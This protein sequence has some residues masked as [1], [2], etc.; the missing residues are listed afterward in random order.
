[1]W[2]GFAAARLGGRVSDISH[3]VEAR[4]SAQPGRLR[5]PRGLHRPRHRHGDAPAAQRAQLRPTRPRARSSSEGSPWRS[6]RWSTLGSR[7]TDARRRRV[8]RRHRRRQLGRALRAHLHA[9][10]RTAPGSSPRSTAAR[11]SWPSSAC[12]TAATSRVHAPVPAALDPGRG[13][14]PPTTSTTS[15]LPLH[16]ARRAPSCTAVSLPRPSCAPVDLDDWSGILLGGGPWNASDPEQPSRRPSAGAEA[17]SPRCSTTSSRGDF[18]FLG[19]CYGIGTLGPHQ[20]GVVDRS[21]A[22]AGGPA[23]GDADRRRARPT[24]CSPGCPATSRRTA[25]TRRRW[26]GCPQSAVQLATSAACPVQAFRVGSNVYATQFHPELD[27]DGRLHPDRGLQERRLL[28]AGPR[29]TRSRRAP[30]AVEVSH[31]MTLL[32]QLRDRPRQVS[33]RAGIGAAVLAL[34]TV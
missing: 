12:P 8:D 25:G 28:P 31:P 33:T 14:L 9:D 24:R 22:R 3:A 5:D 6:S 1:M 7:H 18:P 26:R 17:D 11:R 19:A 20:G 10:A 34:A 16:R 13:R 4:T 29:P 30:R 21:C 32:A 15:F 2:R 27:L 23:V